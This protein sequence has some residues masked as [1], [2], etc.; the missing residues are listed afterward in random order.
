RIDNLRKTNANVKFI[1]FE[2]LI[3]SVGKINLNGIHWVIVGGESGP[4]SRPM[5]EESVL[6]IKNQCEEYS[7]PF[8]FKQWGGVRKKN[9]GRTLLNKTWDEMPVNALS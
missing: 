6:E 4:G 1:S 5:L 3:G 9:N 2:P 8:F 7:V